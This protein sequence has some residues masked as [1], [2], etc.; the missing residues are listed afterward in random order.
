V[1]CRDGTLTHHL[2][3]GNRVVAADM[4]DGSYPQN[5]IDLGRRVVAHE[6][7][8]WG[9]VCGL[10]WRGIACRGHTTP[11]HKALYNSHLD[12]RQELSR[13]RSCCASSGPQVRLAQGRSL[14]DFGSKFKRAMACTRAPWGHRLLHKPA[15]T[16]VYYAALRMRP[17]VPFVR[18]V[19]AR[20]FFDEDMLVVLPEESACQLYY[21][22]M[23]GEDVTTVLLTH[24]R[25]GM[26]FIDVG[27]NLGYFTL[28]AAHLV[29]HSGSVHAFEPAQ[30]TFALLQ[31]NTQ[32]A[33]NIT[34]HQKALWSSRTT[35][36]STITV[37]TTRP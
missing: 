6:P 21:Y 25:A 10:P 33:L 28:L 17:F 18:Q 4:K 20:T 2:L 31:R 12:S 16:I 22:G 3:D 34:V 5:C 29:P 23:I 1:S 36:A 13:S 11:M 26:T 32:A 14:V 9:R 30:Q 15:H 27:A 19:Y 8:G 35:K 7:S 37:H 24:V